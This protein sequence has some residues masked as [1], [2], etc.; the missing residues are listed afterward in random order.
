VVLA[1]GRGDEALELAAR[2]SGPIHLLLTD[3][4]MPG[5]DGRVLAEQLTAL[6]PG[7]RVVY[8]SGYAEQIAE[9]QELLEA[10]DAFLQKP[11]RQEAL[12]L[13]LRQVL[14]RRA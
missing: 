3:L 10:D 11:F 6:R 5:M 7:L 4:V 2:H 8:I 13:K 9:H 14:E 12:L 1:A